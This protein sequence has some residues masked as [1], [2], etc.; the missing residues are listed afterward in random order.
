M[1]KDIK[2]DKN[3]SLK[4]LLFNLKLKSFKNDTK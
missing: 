3:A 4:T 2:N 1:Q